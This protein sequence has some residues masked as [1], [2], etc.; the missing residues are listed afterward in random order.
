MVLLPQML[1][2][3]QR[4]LHKKRSHRIQIQVITSRRMKLQTPTPQDLA[5]QVVA[6]LNRM[7]GKL[8]LYRALKFP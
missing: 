7:I 4:L 5:L 6:R 3:R 8:V 1:D 2:L